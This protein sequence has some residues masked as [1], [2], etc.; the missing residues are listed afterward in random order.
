MTKQVKI[1][2][3]E[4]YHLLLLDLQKEQE[5]FLEGKTAEDIIWY[6][7]NLI[8]NAV[9]T[10]DGL[11]CVWTFT[12]G[13]DVIGCGGIVYFH[14]DCGEAWLLL[15]KEFPEH[16][17]HLVNEIKRQ[18]HSTNL[19]RVHAFTDVGFDRAE[20]FLKWIGFEY[21]ATLE[22]MGMGNR[23]QKIHKIVKR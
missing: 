22:N 18:A 9:P 2:P 3:F 4:P 23:D 8:E 14:S 20:R 16:A 15:G 13:D 5:Y 12:Y 19:Q 7:L 11:H 21:E 17:K 6:G 1:I 10:I